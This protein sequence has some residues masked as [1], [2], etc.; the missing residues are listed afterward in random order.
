VILTS[1]DNV[2]FQHQQSDNPS[3]EDMEP[4]VEETNDDAQLIE[5]NSSTSNNRRSNVLWTTIA[6]CVGMLT[7]SY[8]LISVF[9]YSGFLVIHLLKIQNEDNAAKYAGLIA[10]AFMVGRASTSMI[11]GTIV[12]RY[13]RCFALYTSLL[14]SALFSLLFGFTKSF[15]AAMTIRFFLGCSNGIVST[16]KTV[17][18][19]LYSKNVEEESR[20]M[21]IVMGMWGWGFLISPV[22]S[23]ILAEPVKQYST[24]E[25]TFE[26]TIWGSLL[27]EYPFLLPNLLG[28]FLCISG[29]IL[30][31]FFIHETL[32]KYRQ[33]SVLQD[34]R[35]QLG[36]CLK[37]LP[38]STHRYE[39]LPGIKNS[40]SDTNDDEDGCIVDHDDLSSSKEGVKTE[41]ICTS[42]R[43][44]LSQK[45]TR[46][47]IFLLWGYSFVGLA[48]DEAFP[49]FC[50]SHTAGF[51]I[52]EKDIGK[53]MSFTGLLFAVSQYFVSHYCYAYCGGLS[54]GTKVGAALSA[55]TMFL[56]PISLLINHKSES[57]IWPTSIFLAIVLALH[58]CFS[59]VFFSNIA[60]TMNRTVT[61][62]NRG[63]MNGVAGLG[64][65][66]AKALGPTFAGFL[67]SISI[68]WLQKYASILIFSTLGICGLLIAWGTIVYLPENVS[69][70]DVRDVHVDQ[71]NVDE[72]SSIELKEQ[73]K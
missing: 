67:T 45:D 54:G 49:L 37:Y 18:S 21:N 53:I 64:A 42:M 59:M 52:H 10:S 5:S 47:C 55:P 23:G 24:A 22:V 51:G 40:S 2:I 62:A 65:S 9:P 20:T 36:P 15:T 3:Q 4:L 33:H 28:A 11:W 7:H 31:H 44:I 35:L 50:L 30:V 58:R 29:T 13:G 69:T 1:V 19:D 56:V 73:A 26:G 32:P 38:E 63:M 8:L 66:I 27:R 41:N 61:T 68:S 43:T 39:I 72:V 25:W 12:D 71:P 17:V 34:L 70:D 57:L 16:I 46:T 14:L 48:I 6:L 60:V